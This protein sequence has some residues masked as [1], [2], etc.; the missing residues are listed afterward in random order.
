MPQSGGLFHDGGAQY[1]SSKGFALKSY[2]IAAMSQEFSAVPFADRGRASESLPRLGQRLA[3]ELMLSLASL[4]AHSPDPDGALQLLDRYA[5]AA[6]P[7]VLEGL[8]LHPT[9]L[10]YLVAIFGH[11]QPLAETFLEDSSLAVQFARDRHFTKLR[12]IEDLMQAYARYSVTSPDLWLSSQLARFKRRNILRI[13]L[14]DILR[15]STLG[16]TTL[17]LS[18]L[19][20]VILKNALSYCDQELAK[21]YG[22]PQYRDHEGRV[23]PSGFSIVSLGQLGGNELSYSSNIDLLFLYAREGETAGGSEN[24]SIIANKEYFVRLAEAVNRTVTQPTPH[25]EVY[26]VNLLQRPE[27]EQGDFAISLNSALEYYDHRARGLE[28]QVLMKARHSA[29]DP[30]LTREFLHGVEPYIYRSPNGSKIPP[31]ELGDRENNSVVQH[32]SRDGAMDVRHHRG[33]IRDIDFLVQQLQHM[34]GANDRWVRSGGTLL[35]LRRLNDKGLLSD[36]NYARLTSAYEFIRR[37][38][39][40]IQ[41][42]A[43]PQ[44][45]RLPDDHAALDRLARGVGIEMESRHDAGP[46]LV[47]QLEENFARVDD[48][49]SRVLGAK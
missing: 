46:A 5:E 42:R 45:H 7:D 32:A 26:R 25:G 19:A 4:L 23:A 41:L 12:S 13:A 35:A 47:A 39:H 15:L 24:S 3:P 30:R 1:V 14:K 40:C 20:D 8:A 16:E 9:A 38:E 48:I 27:G 49:Y 2:I 28:L 31:S 44:A 18:T 10:I 34:H 21:R 6:P 29:G 43:D 22:R 37:V 17:E 33:G 11:S 36:A